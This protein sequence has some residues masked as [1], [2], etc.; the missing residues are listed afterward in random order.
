ML[1]FG[2]TLSTNAKKNEVNSRKHP[3]EKRSTKMGQTNL[4]EVQ[5][6]RYGKDTLAGAVVLYEHANHYTSAKYEY[7]SKTD[8]YYRIKIFDALKF[9]LATV[10]VYLYKKQRIRDIKAV[11]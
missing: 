3:Q 11:T 6:I 4:K 2:V 10:A 9:D 8:F 5:M 1:V 7:Q